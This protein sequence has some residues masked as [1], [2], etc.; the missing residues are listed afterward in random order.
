MDT[1]STGKTNR[2]IISVSNKNVEPST[3]TTLMRKVFSSKN[4]FINS[5]KIN[6]WDEMWLQIMQTDRSFCGISLRAIAPGGIPQQ[7]VRGHVTGLI[8][9]KQ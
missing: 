8:P 5:A 1:D 4:G 6:D 7:T 3:L 2:I 9:Y